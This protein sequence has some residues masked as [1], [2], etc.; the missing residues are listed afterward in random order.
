MAGGGIAWK[1]AK[2]EIANLTLDRNN[3]F[4]G[5]NFA[6]FPINL[7]V[8]NSRVLQEG[9][10]NLPPGQ[11]AGITITVELVDHYGQGVV[12]DSSSG[13]TLEVQGSASVSGKTKQVARNGVYVFEEFMVYAIHLER[14]I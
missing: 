7:L 14:L 4:Y 12:T 1:D 5:P 9:L 2:P 10:M 8:K 11:V 6:S 3:A 13:A